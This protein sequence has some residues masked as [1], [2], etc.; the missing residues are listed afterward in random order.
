MIG[1]GSDASED[2]WGGIDE[3]IKFAAALGMWV[4][5]GRLEG[6]AQPFEITRNFVGRTKM[7]ELWILL[8]VRRRL[9]ILVSFVGR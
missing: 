6:V 9:W 3:I 8:I 2:R 7:K 4:G 5:E 1:V